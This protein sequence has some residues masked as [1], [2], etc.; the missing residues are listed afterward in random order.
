MADKLIFLSVGDDSGDLHAANLMRAI[1]ETEPAARFT[2]LGMD[3]M[4]EVGLEPLSPDWERHSS[5]WLRNILR[6]G[7]FRRRLAVCRRFFDSRRP[8]LVIPV[9]FGGFNL[10][11]C[12]VAAARGIP[13]FYYIPPQV[14][15][16]G[17]YRVKK[18]RKWV[19]RAGLIYPFEKDLYA[20]YGV[21]AE[22]LGHPLF[23]ELD[24]NPPSERTVADLRRRFGER[25]IGVFPGSRPQEVI[26][27]MPAIVESC[28]H[29]RRALP[30]ATFA[31]LGGP[32][33]G[34]V[35]SGLLSRSSHEL[36]VLENVRPAELAQA[37]K[38]CITKS[39]TITLEIAS[40]GTPMVIFYRASPLLAFMAYGLSETQVVGLVN[41]LAGRVICPEKATSGNCGRWI[42]DEALKLLQNP[43]AYEACRQAIRQAL[44]GFAQLG[45]SARAARSALSLI[46]RSGQ[47][48]GLT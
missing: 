17:R 42:A 3:R 7:R 36:E 10:C 25:L 31:V 8:D 2:G 43:D 12:K 38:L 30:D 26:A 13:V 18:L 28:G 5:M 41:L 6:A 15:A 29:I 24:R 33:V 4:A 27:H 23:D 11:L 45:A 48:E 46:R 47:D 32:K 37:S 40:Q 1:R 34:D 35:L 14:W 16:H 22:Y 39:G 20:R 19:T 44:L 21:Q 9:D